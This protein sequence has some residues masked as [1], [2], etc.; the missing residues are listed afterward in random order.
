MST[1]D[2]M[3]NIRARTSRFTRKSPLKWTMSMWRIMICCQCM[4][5]VHSFIH[6]WHAPLWL[7]SAKCRHHSSEW[8]I[9]SHVNCFIQGEVQWFQVLL[10]SLHPHSTGASRWSPPVLQEEAVNI[11]LKSDSSGI[12]AMWPNWERRH[13]CTVAERCGMA[14]CKCEM[15]ADEL[16]ICYTEETWWGG[17]YHQCCNTLWHSRGGR[18]IRCG[19]WRF[20][21]WEGQKMF[22]TGC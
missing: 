17:T 3:L 4:V 9:L 5:F 22:A 16:M 2:Y 20:L 7:H 14:L 12:R 13:A 10:G 8:T 6:F 21:C 19:F 15:L 11:C 18:H 1:F